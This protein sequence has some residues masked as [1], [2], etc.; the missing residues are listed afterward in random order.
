MQTLYQPSGLAALV[1]E[2]LERRAL[3][4]YLVTPAQREL[5]LDALARCYCLATDRPHRDIAAL[6]PFVPAGIPLSPAYI[7]A[8][9]RRAVYR[10]I[11]RGGLD[12]DDQLAPWT[13]GFGEG[14]RLAG[15]LRFAEYTEW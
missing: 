4:R 13:A 9:G 12:I 3:S 1:V 2:V 8:M 14:L 10:R 5:L 11:A 15:A 7:E 6:L